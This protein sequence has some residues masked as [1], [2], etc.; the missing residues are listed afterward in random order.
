MFHIWTA[1]ES[2]TKPVK[3]NVYTKIYKNNST[4]NTTAIKN[5]NWTSYGEG[6]GIGQT[7][8]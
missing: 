6:L 5:E 4:V 8:L 1:V 3:T 2:F 7:A